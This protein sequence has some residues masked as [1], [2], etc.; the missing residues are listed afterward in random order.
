[1]SLSLWVVSYIQGIAELAKTSRRTKNEQIVQTIKQW[2]QD[3]YMLDLTI[4]YVAGKVFLAP[5][6]VRKIFKNQMGVTLKDYIV[7]TRMKKACE[8]L[9]S[10][11][12]KVNVVAHAVGYE[13]VSYFC[14]VFKNYYGTTPGEFKDAYQTLT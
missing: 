11:A 12:Y 2:V 14:S 4:E 7:Q 8:L 5:G 6:Y 3:E 10:P 1:D 9:R 13:N